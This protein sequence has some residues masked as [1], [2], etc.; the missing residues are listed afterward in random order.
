MHEF[1]AS[2]T[3]LWDNQ[4]TMKDRLL[5]I[6]KNITLLS[7]LIHDRAWESVKSH[8][9]L[10]IAS[11]VFRAHVSQMLLSLC[12]LLPHVSLALR[13]IVPQMPRALSTVV[14]HLPYILR[15]FVTH[16][17]CNLRT[18][19]SLFPHDIQLPYVLRTLMNFMSRSSRVMFLL[20]L[21][22]FSYLNSF[23]ALNKIKYFNMQLLL[24]KRCSNGFSYKRNKPL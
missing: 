8:T 7:L 5:K 19:V 20:Y 1:W 23:P 17:S 22:C 12:T 18:F 11:H 9:L 15:V 14:I 13:T 6:P 2:I 21:W 16:L 24:K 10:A 3:Q 4:I